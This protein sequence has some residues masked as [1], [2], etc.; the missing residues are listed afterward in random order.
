MQ[1]CPQFT[2]AVH[3][4]LRADAVVVPVNPMNKADE[5]GHYITD[6]GT[7]VVVTTADLAATVAEANAALPEAQRLKHL[8]VT[9]FADAMPAR[10]RPRRAAR[11]P[12]ILAWL[13]AD[14]PL[15][16]GPLPVTR[17][18]DALAA[19][20]V[21][22][23][24]TALPDDLALL[25]Y[26]SG[27]TGLPK[28]CMHTHR[29]LMHNVVGGGL[30]GH[31]GVETT[32]LAVV[33]MFHITGIVYGCLGVVAGGGTAVLMPRWDRE[34]AGRLISRHQVSAL[35]LHPHHG[36]RP[37]RQPQL[38]L[39]RPVQPQVP[40]RRRRGHAAGGGASA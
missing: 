7:K 3:A 9:R 1:N 28:G 17:W 24:H 16:A 30:W 22:G 15:P 39:V 8:L 6:P 26:T 13:Q 14:P 33:P 11:P 21:P 2:V 5:F 40:L 23:P 12:P 25:P 19:G 34:L 38:R 18:T 32:S 35:D 10:Y 31:A 37:V 29:T 20:H 4:I 36:D 27:T